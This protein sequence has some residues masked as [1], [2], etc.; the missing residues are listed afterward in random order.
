MN[1]PIAV[2]IPIG[3][4]QPVGLAGAGNESCDRT[5]SAGE[6]FSRYSSSVVWRAGHDRAAEPK[7]AAKNLARSPDGGPAP[8]SISAR[9]SVILGPGDPTCSS[10]DRH[11]TSTPH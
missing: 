1:R 5:E 8:S 3:T 4:E 10:N 9:T 11:H 7:G 2:G 6:F